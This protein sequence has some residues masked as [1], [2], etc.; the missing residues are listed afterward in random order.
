MTSRSTTSQDWKMDKVVYVM[1]LTAV[2][3]PHC[4]AF[5]LQQTFHGKGG[6]PV[7]NPLKDSS[8]QAWHAK[9]TLALFQQIWLSPGCKWC[10]KGI[11]D[12]LLC[13]PSPGSSQSC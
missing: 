9:G 7:F 1:L 6:L 3:S 10:E 2:K 11:T 12:L 13:M 5:F 8:A 4:A